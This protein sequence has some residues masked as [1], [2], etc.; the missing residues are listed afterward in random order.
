MSAFDC[1][2]I[3]RSVDLL[4]R[5]VCRSPVVAGGRL[6]QP[7]RQRF[8]EHPAVAL[9][10]KVLGLPF[11]VV[12]LALLGIIA[13]LLLDLLLC[14]GCVVHLLVFQVERYVPPQPSQK[15]PVSR[16]PQSVRQSQKQL[17]LRDSNSSCTSIGLTC[18]LTIV[19]CISLGFMKSSL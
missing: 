9:F 10:V 11:D 18:F 16:W 14:H 7:S 8:D 4:F 12:L 3:A 1:V 2:D 5:K 19:D 17:H 6:C 13:L 15:E